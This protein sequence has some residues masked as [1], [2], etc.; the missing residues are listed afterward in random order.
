MAKQAN[1]AVFA[2][3]A[4]RSDSYGM[5]LKLG[6]G[7]PGFRSLTWITTKSTTRPERSPGLPKAGTR[8]KDKRS[9]V[10]VDH[11]P[12]AAFVR[13]DSA[14][15]SGRTTASHDQVNPPVII[16]I[17]AASAAVPFQISLS[18][19]PLSPSA[20]QCGRADS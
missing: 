11:R 9:L 16:G 2:K 13:K 8:P 3:L 20:M 14:R 4:L 6:D 5:M 17:N 7:R 1:G 10:P 18:L 19:A 15:D 12:M